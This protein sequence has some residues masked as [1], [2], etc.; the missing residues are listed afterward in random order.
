MSAKDKN[1][2]T[3]FSLCLELDNAPVMEVLIS[4]VS[5]NDDS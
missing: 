1:N 3:A 2:K 5:L 4:K